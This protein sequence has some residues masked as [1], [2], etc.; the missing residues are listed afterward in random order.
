MEL[1]LQSADPWPA[2]QLR[3]LRALELLENIATPEAQSI[4]EAVA[5]GAPASRLTKEAKDCLQRLTR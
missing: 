2:E 1:V 5:Q 3:F 4:L